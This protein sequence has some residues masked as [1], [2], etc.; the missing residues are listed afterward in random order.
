MNLNDFAY[1]WTSNKVASANSAYARGLDCTK[2]EIW[3]D[4]NPFSGGLTVSCV[5][6]TQKAIDKQNKVSK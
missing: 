5:K 2:K 3:E 1:W 4:S 6:M